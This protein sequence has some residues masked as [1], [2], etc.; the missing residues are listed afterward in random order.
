MTESF[1]KLIV[2]S[3]RLPMPRPY[4][5]HITGSCVCGTVRIAA[6]DGLWRWMERSAPILLPLR[7]SFMPRMWL[8]S[9]CTGGPLLLVS[10]G[11]HMCTYDLLIKLCVSYFHARGLVKAPTAAFKLNVVECRWNHF[12]HNNRIGWTFARSTDTFFRHSVSPLSPLLLTN[13]PHIIFLSHRLTLPFSPGICDDNIPAG[14][15]EAVLNIGRCN[16]S[17]ETYDA[18]TGFNA[19]STITLEEMPLRKY[20]YRVLYVK[21]LDTFTLFS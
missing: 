19:P 5:S 17:N 6:C 4:G 3:T 2:P 20:K 21:L 14:A 8:G 10:D 13:L 11:R 15:V 9:V 16:G 1:Q 18:Y 12:L 7:L